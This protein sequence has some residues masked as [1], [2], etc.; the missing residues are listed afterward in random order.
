MKTDKSSRPTFESVWAEIQ[1][2]NRCTPSCA[3]GRSAASPVS[4]AS[5]SGAT[6]TPHGGKF[7]PVAQVKLARSPFRDS[8][9]DAN[10]KRQGPRAEVCEKLIE[11]IGCDRFVVRAVPG[12]LAFEQDE[13][14]D[15]E[16]FGC[17]SARA[18]QE[19]SD[20]AASAAFPAGKCDV[21]MKGA[22]LGFKADADASA[23]DLGGKRR[24]RRL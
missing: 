22:M 19:V 23:L 9:S 16:R 1:P 8:P 5:P 15:I 18:F 20:F 17:Q 21:R 14:V 3:A 11:R 2:S 10:H 13:T 24:D 12:E 6:H 7:E 4:T